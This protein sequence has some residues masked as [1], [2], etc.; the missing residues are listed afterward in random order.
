MFMVMDYVHGQISENDRVPG[1]P[2]LHKQPWKRL[3]GMSYIKQWGT[4]SSAPLHL[5][6]AVIYEPIAARLTYSAASRQK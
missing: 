2:L 1:C 6:A 5:N 4:L 3:A